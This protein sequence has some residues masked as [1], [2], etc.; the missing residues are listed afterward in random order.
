[1]RHASES[2]SDLTFLILVLVIVVFGLIMLT[3]ASG[4]TGYEDHSDSFYFVRHQLLFG[5]FHS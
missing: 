1:M 3:S 2:R 5:F 4:P